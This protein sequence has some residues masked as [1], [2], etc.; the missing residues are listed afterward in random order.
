MILFLLRLIIKVK[1]LFN[2]GT[3]L[4]SNVSFELLIFRMFKHFVGVLWIQV[5]SGTLVEVV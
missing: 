2:N 4:L 3:L 1:S 5:G